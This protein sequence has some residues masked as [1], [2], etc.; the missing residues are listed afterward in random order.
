MVPKHEIK[1]QHLDTLKLI[2]T[3]SVAYVR[4]CG[5]EYR[6]SLFWVEDK[7]NGQVINHV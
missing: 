7:N 2:I 1:T 6:R 4:V 5:A 3:C